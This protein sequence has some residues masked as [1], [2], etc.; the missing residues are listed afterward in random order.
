MAVFVPPPCGPLVV[1]TMPKTGSAWVEVAL[2]LA[3][4]AR[5]DS[6]HAPASN[7]SKL[8]LPGGTR[9]YGTVRDPSPW[10]VSLW[11]H[12]HA[13]GHAG[14]RALLEWTGS[15]EATFGVFLKAV[16]GPEPPGIH[17]RGAI[18][19]ETGDGPGGLWSRLTRYAYGDG[20][21]GWAVDG[22]LRTDSLAEDLAEIDV[23]I[24]DGLVPPRNVSRDKE[25]DP[26][27]AP[28]SEEQHEAV[29]EAD[30][31]VLAAL[32][33]LLVRYGATSSTMG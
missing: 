12:L 5:V 15:E 8:A 33:P 26:G 3:G 28:Q 6:Q 1:W 31:P 11:R 9:H 30:G 23:E 2:G 27:W 24:P 18:L 17:W 7:K 25:G 22:F 29:W 19:E 14:R 20:R 16:L 32:R 21:G 13:S 10:Y 4:G